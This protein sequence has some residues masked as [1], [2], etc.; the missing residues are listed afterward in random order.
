VKASLGRYVGVIT[1]QAD[2][3]RNQAPV[4]QMVTSATRNW[5]DSNGD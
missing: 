4:L 3:L 1:T 2:I 5:A